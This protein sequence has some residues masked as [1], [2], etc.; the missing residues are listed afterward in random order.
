[1]SANIAHL[2]HYKG[3]RNSV[4]IKQDYLVTPNRDFREVAQVAQ[5]TD[6]GDDL[7]L[8][9]IKYLGPVNVSALRLNQE[10]SGG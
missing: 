7:E 9:S 10:P 8:S 2:W 4:V 6:Q 5:Q 1:M 3:C